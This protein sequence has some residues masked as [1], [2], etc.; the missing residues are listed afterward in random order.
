MTGPKKT[1]KNQKEYTRRYLAREEIQVQIM[2]RDL[3]LRRGTGRAQP[4]RTSEGVPTITS[5][6]EDEEGKQ[7][8][9]RIDSGKRPEPRV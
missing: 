4:T 3:Q 8:E 2:W 6:F 9:S 5:I 1:L 7:A